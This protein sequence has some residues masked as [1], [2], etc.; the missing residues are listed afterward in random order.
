MLL[1]LLAE[2]GAYRLDAL[3]DVLQLADSELSRDDMQELVDKALSELCGNDLIEF[4]PEAT[5]VSTA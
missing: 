4:V 2:R 3:A 5:P 1:T